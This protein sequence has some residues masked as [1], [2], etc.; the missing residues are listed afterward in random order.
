MIDRIDIK[1][2]ALDV[3][4][5]KST[6]NHKNIESIETNGVTNIISKGI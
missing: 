5:K 4:Q 3:Q 6:H 2:R 1:L